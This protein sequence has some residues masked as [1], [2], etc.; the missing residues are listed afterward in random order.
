VLED[1]IWLHLQTVRH[2]QARHPPKYVV[3]DEARKMGELDLNLVEKI[4][5]RPVPTSAREYADRRRD[6][7]SEL[8]ILR[9][10]FRD[11]WDSRKDRESTAMQ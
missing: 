1:F 9:K 3:E 8:S 5:P 4:A 6:Y 2:R 10:Q 7:Q 11:E